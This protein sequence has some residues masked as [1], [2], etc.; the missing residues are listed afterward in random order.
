MKV[1]FQKLYT[2][3]VSLQNIVS[4]NDRPKAEVSARKIKR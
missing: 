3:I 1:S 4:N 2:D